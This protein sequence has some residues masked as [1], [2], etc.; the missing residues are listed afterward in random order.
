MGSSTNYLELELLDH[1][2]GTGVAFS[3]PGQVYCALF[4]A[5]PGEGGGGTE[6]AGAGYVRDA[7]NFNAASGASAN[8]TNSNALS[9]TATGGNF[10]TVVAIGLFDQSSGGNMLFYSDLSVNKTVNDGDTLDIAAGAISVT[11]T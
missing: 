9:W 4:T 1:A 5:A 11:L 7:V 10:G 3:Q 2:L 6:V 8:A